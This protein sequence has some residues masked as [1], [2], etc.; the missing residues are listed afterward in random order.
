LGDAVG[1]RQLDTENICNLIRYFQKQNQKYR[2]IIHSDEDINN[3]Q[4]DNTIIY[5]KS[6]DVINVFSDFIH[7]DILVINYS[8]ISIAAHLL[9]DPSQ[10][11]ICPDKAGVTFKHRILKKCITCSEILSTST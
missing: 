10:V 7:A 6:V 8:A 5:N 11:V 2:V 9:G 3:L 4:F 1:S